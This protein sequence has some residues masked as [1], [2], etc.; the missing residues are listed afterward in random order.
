M[1]ATSSTIQQRLSPCLE[2]MFA[3]P[4][5][6]G[7]RIGEAGK[8]GMRQ[9]EFW[10]WRRRDVSRMSRDTFEDPPD[11]RLGRSSESAS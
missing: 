11:W 6:I 1:I 8:D 4:E 2:W 10:Y 7:E 5:D 3:E 9:V